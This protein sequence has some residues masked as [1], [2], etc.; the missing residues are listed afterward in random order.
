MEPQ[1]RKGPRYHLPELRG[2]REGFLVGFVVAIEMQ[3][4]GF[5]LRTILRRKLGAGQRSRLQR[6]YP[7]F[8]TLSN[9][10]KALVHQILFMLFH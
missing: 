1:R 7:I 2:T 5:L 4:P 3:A 6:E 8:G 10:W 9:E